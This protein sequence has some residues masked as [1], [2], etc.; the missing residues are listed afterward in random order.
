[1][2]FAVN[3][4]DIINP[5]NHDAKNYDNFITVSVQLPVRIGITD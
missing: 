4:R 5:N 2:R 1:M 3:N